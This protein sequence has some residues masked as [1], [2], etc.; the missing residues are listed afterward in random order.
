[1][2]FLS[3][4]KESLGKLFLVCFSALN[5]SVKIIACLLFSSVRPETACFNIYRT[6]N[7]GKDIDAGACRTCQNERT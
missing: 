3:V 4:I 2:Y 5:R 6:M 7:L 1:M